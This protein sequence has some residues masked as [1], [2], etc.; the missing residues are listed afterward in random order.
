MKF[1]TY[2]VT[3]YGYVSNWLDKRQSKKIWT[4]GRKAGEGRSQISL[5]ICFLGTAAQVLSALNKAFSSCWITRK[6][7][8]VIS[9]SVLP[10]DLKQ[11]TWFRTY[12]FEQDLGN[13]DSIVTSVWAHFT[14][15]HRPMLTI[16]SWSFVLE[17][18]WLTFSQRMLSAF[19]KPKEDFWNQE[20]GGNCNQGLLREKRRS[21]CFHEYLNVKY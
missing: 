1:F 2:V 18:F 11:K 10:T 6:H 7:S 21:S 19:L 9:F 17:S 12:S 15:S 20:L 8:Q 4:Y 16:S 14:D 3:R 5:Q 13:P